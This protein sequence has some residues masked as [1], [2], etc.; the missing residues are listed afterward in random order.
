[1]EDNERALYRVS[2]ARNIG[3]KAKVA[4]N[5]RVFGI[6]TNTFRNE[7]LGVLLWKRL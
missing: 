6:R 7:K 2:S 5:V 3:E 1:L 4:R